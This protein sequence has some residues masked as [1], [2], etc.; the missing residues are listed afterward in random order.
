MGEGNTLLQSQFDG[1]AEEGEVRGRKSTRAKPLTPRPGVLGASTPFGGPAP[2]PPFR[3]PCLCSASLAWLGLIWAGLVF[4]PPPKPL[5][6]PSSQVMLEPLVD[7]LA[8]ALAAKPD[9][10]QPLPVW[11]ALQVGGW[12][13]AVCGGREGEGDD[14]DGTRGVPVSH[15]CAAFPSLV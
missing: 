10:V 11:M 4:T 14:G 13:G 3:A 7:A 5:P 8:A 12:G 2:D 6:P 15:T 1:A 9:W